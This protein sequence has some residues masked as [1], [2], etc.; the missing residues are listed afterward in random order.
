MRQDQLFRELA[1]MVERERW[2]KGS[3]IKESVNPSPR[4]A[5]TCWGVWQ[6]ACREHQYQN[7][8][9]SPLHDLLRLTV[10]VQMAQPSPAALEESRSSLVS[11]SCINTW[12]RFGI[13]LF[14]FPPSQSVA[15]VKLCSRWEH[16]PCG[17]KGVG[18]IPSKM[19][20]PAW[21]CRDFPGLQSPGRF[22]SSPANLVGSE[23]S[24]QHHVEGGSTWRGREG[25]NPPLVAPPALLVTARG[26]AAESW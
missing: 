16:L 5:G 3:C 10:A 8:S 11:F 15:D 21:C 6:K 23:V 12:S 25:G 1:Q 18:D 9:L 2:I 20:I 26:Q 7:P 4:G 19:L 13:E 22:R 17:G 24:L 14:C